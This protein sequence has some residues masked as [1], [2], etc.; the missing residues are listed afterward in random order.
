M[1]AELDVGVLFG[2]FVHPERDGGGAAELS[3]KFRVAVRKN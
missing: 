3:V 1:A 2:A